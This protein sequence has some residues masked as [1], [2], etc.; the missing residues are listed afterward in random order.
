M[1]RIN[2]FPF[3]VSLVATLSLLMFAFLFSQ[4]PSHAQTQAWTCD[5]VSGIS[6]Q[7]CDALQAL[8]DVGF[9]RNTA[10]AVTWFSNPNA[11]SWNKQGTTSSDRADQVICFRDGTQRI[12]SLALSSEIAS[13]PSQID[14]LSHL[15]HLILSYNLEPQQ[16]PFIQISRLPNLEYLSLSNNMSLTYIPAEINLLTNLPEL[17]INANPNLTTLPAEI[18]NL[19]SLEQLNMSFNPSLTTLPPEIG[20]LSS[21]TRLYLWNNPALSTIP[22]TI[23]NLQNLKHLT[24]NNLGVTGLPS[25]MGNLA[26]LEELTIQ[27]NTRLQSLPPQIGDIYGLDRL[28]IAQNPLLMSIP[29]ELARENF[30]VGIQYYV[31]VP[32][33][34]ELP[35]PDPTECVIP[36]SG[37]WPPCATQGDAPPPDLPSGCVIPLS[38]PWPPC[39][40]Q[41]DTPPPDLPPGCVIP[42]SGPWPPCATGGG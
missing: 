25:Q 28:I 20:N 36:P 18:G 19:S 31:D 26:L 41:G 3:A 22:P 30:E 5:D 15:R 10:P 24:F 16:L 11:C 17:G 40:T 38:G 13:F 14:G 2:K 34:E 23:G 12:F 21:L 42:P 29:A 7:E 4:Q 32:V 35:G 9:G 6:R 33:E 37:P 8:Y 27:N 1:F 39:A